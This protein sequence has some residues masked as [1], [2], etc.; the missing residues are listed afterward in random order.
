MNWEKLES[1][2]QLEEIKK[3]SHDKSVLIFKHSTTCSISSMAWDRLNRNW[4]EEDTINIKPYYL[5]LH[6]Y[7]EVSNKVAEEFDVVHQS[8][9]VL[10]VQKGEVK[11]ANSHM[12]INYKEILS[13]V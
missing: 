13:K 5:D 11:Y 4:K 7:R 8:P 9:Q 2:A 6:S 10:L 12:G 1:L 3:E